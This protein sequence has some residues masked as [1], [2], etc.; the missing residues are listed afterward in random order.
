MTPDPVTAKQPD[1]PLSRLAA[2]D[3]QALLDAPMF[4][5][6]WR[7][8]ASISL[9]LPRFRSG[10]KIAPQLQRMQA[11]DLLSVVFPDQLACAENVAGER[12]VP[13]QPLV[14]QTIQDSNCCAR[15]RGRK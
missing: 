1:N 6:R 7:W 15:K 2:A 14:T 12:E 8:V 11:E 10:K 4:T 9:A 3:L 5:I 13:D